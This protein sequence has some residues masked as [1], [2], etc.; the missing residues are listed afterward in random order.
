[1]G[2]SLRSRR[3]VGA[4]SSVNSLHSC[5][6]ETRGADPDRTLVCAIRAVVYST[7]GCKQLM[8]VGRGCLLQG[9]AGGQGPTRLG[10]VMPKVIA[11]GWAC[12]PTRCRGQI[13]GS[14]KRDAVRVAM[15]ANSQFRIGSLIS[16]LGCV[17]GA[18]LSIAPIAA[19][20]RPKPL[21]TVWEL[22]CRSSPPRTTLSEVFVPGTRRRRS[23]GPKSA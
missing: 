6:I 16:W 17:L 18:D 14:R 9:G 8:R 19:G 11:V 10:P 20:R 2:R 13:P 4:R 21:L 22:N 5:G 3:Q 15:P 23:G 1:V 12:A 7:Q